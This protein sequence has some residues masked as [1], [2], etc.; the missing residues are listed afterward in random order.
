MPIPPSIPFL[1]P[2]LA[3]PGLL[4]EIYMVIGKL[5]PVSWLQGMEQVTQAKPIHTHSSFGCSDWLRGGHMTWVGPIR[6]TF[7]MLAGIASF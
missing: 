4:R 6:A 3:A 1:P 5:P 7:R 2:S